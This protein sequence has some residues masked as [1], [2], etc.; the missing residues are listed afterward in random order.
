MQ[1]EASLCLERHIVHNLAQ[2]SSLAEDPELT[3]SPGAL[4]QHCAYIAKL[5]PA[6]EFVHD[7]IYEVQVF[8]DQFARG[9]LH[10]LAEVDHP[11]IE[12]VP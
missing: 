12:P 8:Q 11:P 2:A 5:I 9:K 7:I 6:V 3:V 4:L 10:L 1:L